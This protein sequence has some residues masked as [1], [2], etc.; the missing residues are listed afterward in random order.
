M[1][2]RILYV[3]L[4]IISLILI[5]LSIFLNYYKSITDVNKNINISNDIMTIDK[6]YS[7][8][9]DNNLEQLEYLKFDFKNTK[10]ISNQSLLNL[11]FYHLNETL[12][13]KKGVSSKVFEDYLKNI[14]GSNIKISHE[15]IKLINHEEEVKYDDKSDVY[16]S[17]KIIQKTNINIYNK[18]LS[19]DYKDNK[20]YLKQ[21]KFYIK[22][23][24]V[25]KS[26]GDYINNVDVLMK[27][28]DSENY[29]EEIN[30]N[31]E[32]IKNDIYTY[33]YVFKKEDGDI[34]LEK[35]YKN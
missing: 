11:A 2:K 26:Y 19:F 35:Y 23:N 3:L 15:T 8:I 14:F 20:Y 9:I 24:N 12:D 18:L 10:N 22:N 17:S 33:T 31:I 30:K 34:I 6:V 28:V 7:F 27:I 16:T 29:E 13:F 32:N 21:N 25:F 4:S 5:Y 1:N